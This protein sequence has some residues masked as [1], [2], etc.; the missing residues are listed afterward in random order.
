MTVTVDIP[1]SNTEWTQVA[2]EDTS[3]MFTVFAEHP[4]LFRQDTSLPDTSVVTGHW[5]MPG[6]DATRYL[7]E[8]GEMAYARSRSP[9]AAVIVRTEDG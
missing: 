7:M 3:G 4:V 1:I 6:P 9:S 8:A 2:S 5:L